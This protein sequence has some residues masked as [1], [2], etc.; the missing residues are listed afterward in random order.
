MNRPNV[1]RALRCTQP[2]SVTSIAV[3]SRASA[4]RL[5]PRRR[6]QRSSKPTPVRQRPLNLGE[7]V[8]V[9]H[10]VELN[11]GVHLRPTSTRGHTR[12]GRGDPPP[13]A[14]QRPSTSTLHPATTRRSP[15]PGRHR[16]NAAE[17]RLPRGLGG[18]TPTDAALGRG[19]SRDVG[20]TWM[21]QIRALRAL[22]LIDEHG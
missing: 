2:P 4:G 8:E 10:R 17:H 11:V 14:H 15:T 12:T 21:R 20:S 13:S 1:A 9:S 22:T 5:L 18:A 19:R 16:S 7:L 3:A 6:L